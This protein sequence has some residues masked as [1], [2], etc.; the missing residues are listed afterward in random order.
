[1][2][3]PRMLGGERV[4]VQRGPQGH[5]ADAVDDAEVADVQMDV[6]LLG[7]L[8]LGA[9]DGKPCRRRPRRACANE[10]A[11]GSV[12]SPPSGKQLVR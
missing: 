5:R 9:R 11:R 7:Q 2:R 6:G 4:A 8:A 3:L 10:S 1:M 12:L